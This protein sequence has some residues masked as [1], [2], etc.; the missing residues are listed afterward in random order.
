LYAEA[1]LAKKPVT[2]HLSTTTLK[3]AYQDEDLAFYTVTWHDD[4]QH[5]TDVTSA[6]VLETRYRSSQL[7]LWTLGP[8]EWVLFKKLPE[9]AARVKRKR[10]DVIQLSLPGMDG[11]QQQGSVG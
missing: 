8:D 2:V 4:H 5:I 9:Y 6:R 3:V 7:T 11:L 10:I 1:G